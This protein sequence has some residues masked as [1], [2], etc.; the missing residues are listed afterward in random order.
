MIEVGQPTCGDNFSPTPSLKYVVCEVF[1]VYSN[2]ARHRVKTML[3]TKYITRQHVRVYSM[4]N[5]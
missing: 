4:S 2:V 5:Q 3:L 1:F